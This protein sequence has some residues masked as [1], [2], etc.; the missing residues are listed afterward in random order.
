MNRSY[1]VLISLPF[2]WFSCTTLASTTNWDY[3]GGLVVTHQS[4]NESHIND[5]NGASLDFIVSR[6]TAVG[7]W[8]AFIEAVT[9]P[10]ASGVSSI[11]PEANADAGSALDKDN[12]GR[13][14]VSELYYQHRLNAKRVVTAGLVDVSGF[15]EQSRIVSDETT[16]FLGVS[17]TGNVTIEFPD[18]TPGLVYEHTLDSGPVLRAAITSSNGLADNPERS[19]A[20]LFSVTED[21]KGIFAIISASWKQ[22]DWLLR[23]GAWT[24]TSDHDAIDGSS[25]GH[26]NFGGYLLAGY[27]QG[28]HALNVRLGLADDKVSQASDFASLGYRFKHGDYVL[29]AGAAHIMLSSN[30][31][32][33]VLGDTEHYEIYLRYAFDQGIFLTGDLQHIYNSNFGELAE[34]RNEGITIYGL[35]FTWLY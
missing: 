16:Q 20:Q 33:P 29:G 5:E 28:Q 22:K 7:E 14:Q 11:L 32:N 24:N 4:T 23:A 6:K 12:K 35:R 25:S 34:N 10:E 18:Y 26:D 30:E 13:V 17:F 19:Y 9:T 21:G 1:I 15:F 8:R 27:K 3:S 31:P 2:F